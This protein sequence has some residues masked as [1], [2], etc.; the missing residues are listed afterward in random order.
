MLGAPATVTASS[1]ATRTC[2]TSPMPC[3]GAPVVELGDVTDATAGR[4]PSTSTA[5]EPASVSVAGSRPDRSRLA[6]LPASS[7]I[8][9]PAPSANGVALA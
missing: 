7:L 9:T 6:S 1:N 8:D 2:T 4:L 3:G 5:D